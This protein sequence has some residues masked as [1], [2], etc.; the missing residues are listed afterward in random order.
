MK[1]GICANEAKDKQ[2]KFTYEI[3]DMLNGDSNE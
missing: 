3:I 1:I 2:L